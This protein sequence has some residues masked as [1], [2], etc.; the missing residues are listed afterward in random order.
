MINKFLLDAG[1]GGEIRT[2]GRV[3]PTAVFKTAALNHSATPPVLLLLMSRRAGMILFRT[4]FCQ[5]NSV[6]SNRSAPLSGNF[7]VVA[8]PYARGVQS[9]V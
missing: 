4:Y 1:G 9:I 5:R 6:Y 7:K 3:T 8:H 2:H